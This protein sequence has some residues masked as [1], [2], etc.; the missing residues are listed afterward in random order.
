MECLTL[1]GLEK[2]IPE[3][4]ISSGANNVKK[5]KKKGRRRFDAVLVKMRFI[6]LPVI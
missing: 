5:K 2:K 1:K 6:I 3:S 4:E